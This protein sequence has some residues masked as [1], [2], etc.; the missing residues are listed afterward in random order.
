MKKRFIFGALAVFASTVLFERGA[1][2]SPKI[3]RKISAWV[4]YAF[5]LLTSV[6]FRRHPDP[7]PARL[8]LPA[9]HHAG[10]DGSAATGHWS[11]GTQNLHPVH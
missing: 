9:G 11:A 1:R 2:Q 6:V 5:L 10:H 8:I 7:A 4:M 3:V